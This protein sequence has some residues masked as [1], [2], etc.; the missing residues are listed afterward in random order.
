MTTPAAALGTSTPYV[1]PA[2]LI[3][4]P[5]GIS[6]G[7]VGAVTRP[8]P[9]QQLAEQQNLCYRATAM[10]DG[11]CNQPLRATL[12]TETLYGPGDMRFTMR[13]V[14]T[15]L[16]LSRSPV[17]SVS[18]GRAA[19]AG[20]F[21]AQWTP[22]PAMAFRPEKPL[23]GVYGTTSPG[24]SGDGGAGVL[25]APGYTGPGRYQ[26]MVECTYVNGWPHTG[27]T[28]PAA[29]GDMTLSVDDCTGWGAPPG[30]SSGAAGTVHDPGQQEAVTV[31]AA[32]ASSGP[33][34]LSLA[35]PL[36]F[37]HLAGIMVTTLPGTV[38]QAAILFAT[39]QALTRG[40]MSTTIQAVPGSG[41][42]GG[43][44]AQTPQALA[45]AAQMLIQPFR[46][47]I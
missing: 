44:A 32:S 12:D 36:A 22:I 27:L 31:L 34:V 23:I 16:L 30:M 5:T 26:W 37:P 13:G 41:T 38:I 2:A 3:A 21:P 40:A 4:A 47:V 33:G 45:E 15:R 20:G 28:A 25:L 6:W 18:G 24:A 39:S 29:E 11:Y 46:R 1:T 9:A 7:S 35:S 19:F 43:K 10:I 42:S 8:T 14:I 17:T